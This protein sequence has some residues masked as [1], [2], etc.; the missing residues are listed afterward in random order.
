MFSDSVKDHG[1][2]RPYKEY[3]IDSIDSFYETDEEKWERINFVDDPSPCP[4]Y[5]KRRCVEQLSTV[6]RDAYVEDP[7][8]GPDACEAREKREFRCESRPWVGGCSNWGDCKELEILRSVGDVVLGSAC[9]GIR[10]K[11]EDVSYGEDRDIPW[12]LYDYAERTGYSGRSFGARATMAEARKIVAEN[13][14]K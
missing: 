6:V 7:F 10:P 1:L 3:E 4:K 13:L 2:K 11:P 12:T 5:F 8:G 14:D 9:M